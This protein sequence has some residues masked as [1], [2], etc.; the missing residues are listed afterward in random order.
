[1]SYNIYFFLFFVLFFVIP[2]N[3]LTLH[4]QVAILYTFI[5]LFFLIKITDF[6]NLKAYNYA[7]GFVTFLL[8]GSIYYTI[9]Q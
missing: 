1:M 5:L 7:I 9:V 2:S 3:Y 8:I 4:K 6:R